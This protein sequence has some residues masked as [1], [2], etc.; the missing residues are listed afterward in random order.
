MRCPICKAEGRE[1]RLS[2]KKVS[3][4]ILRATGVEIF[5]DEQDRKHIH[6][7]ELRTF[8][9]TCSNGHHFRH[10]MMSRCTIRDCDWN[11]KPEVQNSQKTLEE[12][13]NES[14]N[15]SVPRVSEPQ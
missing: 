3:P 12:V 1:H 11:D 7:C 6:D 5:Y 9:Y 15:G 10:D 14:R 8:V 2:E 13:Y 4:S